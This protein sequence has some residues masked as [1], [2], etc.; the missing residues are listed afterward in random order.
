MLDGRLE[1]LAG[2]RRPERIGCDIPF[3]AAPLS[4][5]GIEGGQ[6]RA[7]DPRRS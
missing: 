2:E 3:A 7:T 5:G 1:E 4:L 6:Q